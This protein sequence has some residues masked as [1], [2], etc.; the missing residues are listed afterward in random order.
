MP[1]TKLARQAVVAMAPGVGYIRRA[2]S[3]SMMNYLC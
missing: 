2:E 1:W 3:S